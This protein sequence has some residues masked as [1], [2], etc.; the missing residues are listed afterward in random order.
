V[1]YRQRLDALAAVWEQWAEVGG[2]LTDVEWSTPSRCAGWDVAALFAH[3]GLFPQAV[4]DPPRADGG[5]PVTAVDI[6]RGFNAPGGVAHTMADQVANGAVAVAAQVGGSG[7]VALFADTG[8]RGIAALRERPA[9]GL[10]PWPAAAAVTTWSEAVRIVL[11]ES[12][13]HLLDVLDGL[14]RAPHLPPTALREAAH[15]LAELADPVAF[16]EAATGR[17]LESP[18]PVLR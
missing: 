5:D 12:E 14:G 1:E 6:L 17:A 8:P 9:D 10:V 16:V 2:A 11:L 15:L 7:L 18:L 3:V 4:L 13:V